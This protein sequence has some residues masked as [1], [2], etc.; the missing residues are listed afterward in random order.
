MIDRDIQLKLQAY[1]DGELSPGDARQVE[2]QLARDPEAQALLAELQNTNG[3]LAGFE[4]DLKLPESREFYWS[5]IQREIRALE[6][7]AA[8]VPAAK[9]WLAVWRRL[10]V[11]AGAAAALLLAGLLALP[12]RALVPASETAVAGADTFTYRDYKTETTLVWVSYPVKNDLAD[13]DPAD[14]FE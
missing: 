13:F 7:K 10:L 6:A 11:P 3:A 1:L 5:K 2:A 14:S 9:S 12:N 4:A 8:P